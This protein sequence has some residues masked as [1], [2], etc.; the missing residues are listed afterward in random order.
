MKERIIKIKPILHRLLRPGT[1]WMLLLTVLSATALIFTFTTDRQDTIFAYVSYILSAYAL[2]TLVFGFVP[3]VQTASA[4]VKGFISKNKYGRRYLN[5]MTFQAMI[6]LYFSL[7][8]NL[9]Y[10]VYQL[11]A[12][13]LFASFWFGAMAVYYIVLCIV[14][15][16]LLMDV[17]KY[18]NNL[19]KE[20][21]KYRLCGVLLFLLNVALTGVVYQMVNQG[22]GSKYPGLLIYP[23]AIYAF[24]RMTLSIVGMIKFR[25]LN[26]PVLSTSRIINLAAALVSMFSLQIAMFASFS[27]GAE[28]EYIMNS[29]SGG[30]V[31][32]A[33]FS[34]A[35]F[36]VMRANLMLKKLGINNS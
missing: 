24:Y 29:I 27:D 13:I 19:R 3:A 34:M 28:F 7:S 15:F 36:M 31:C 14:R 22:Q 30:C 35:V 2:V 6:S 16:L 4:R 12:G 17:R 9:A 32:F 21:R 23:V 25:K 1:G 10:A 26:S 5:D 18:E 33:I 11:V 20:Y 8:V